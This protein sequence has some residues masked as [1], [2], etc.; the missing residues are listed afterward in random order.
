MNGTMMTILGITFIFFMTV[1]GAATV[2]CFKREI[3]PRLQAAI[4][5]F[6][7]GVMLAASVWSLLLPALSQAENGWGRYAFIPVFIGFLAGGALIVGVDRMLTFR[8][9]KIN[10]GQGLLAD[11]RARKLF[12]S[13]TLHNIP[14]GLAVGFAFGAAYAVGTLAAYVAALG[15]AIGVG[16]QNLPEGAA[17]SLPIKTALNSKHKAFLYGFIS[18]VTEPIFALIGYFFAARLQILQPWLLAF[19]AGAMIFVVAEELLPESQTEQG[20]SI[21]AWGAMF[22]FAFMMVLDVALG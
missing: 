16:I 2:Y 14:E 9:C 12:L 10:K 22:G 21:G 20:D 8:Q 6:A 15:L 7:A 4:F 3:P 19:S 11:G 1:L 13:M 17:V 5:G 18:A